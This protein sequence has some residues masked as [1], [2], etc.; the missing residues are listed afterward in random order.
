[1]KGLTITHNVNSRAVFANGSVKA[2][3][4]VVHKMLAYTI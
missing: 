2:A 3:L 4:F 1:M